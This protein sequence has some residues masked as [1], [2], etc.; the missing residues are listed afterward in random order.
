MGLP[1]FEKDKYLNEYIPQKL[2]TLEVCVLACHTLLKG[3]ETPTQLYIN[4]GDCE[5]KDDSLDLFLDIAIDAGLL[6][7]RC[8]LNFMGI[9]KDNGT[10]ENKDYGENI[11]AFSLEHVAIE[12]AI[13]I[14]EEDISSSELKFYWIKS[15]DTASKGIAHFTTEG[16]LINVAQLGYACFATVSLVRKY[17]YEALGVEQA[18]SLI[19]LTLQPK[20]GTIW[21]AIY[22]EWEVER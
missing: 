6:A 3:S 10:I 15:L 8:L 14:L 17:L 20:K 12:T 19:P 4:L 16:S 22:D 2:K 9:K 18:E 21:D 5:L 1:L 13:K 11:K 7:N